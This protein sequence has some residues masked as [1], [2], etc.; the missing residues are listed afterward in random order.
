MRTDLRSADGV[1]PVHQVP[2]IGHA[3]LTDVGVKRSHNQDAF[4]VHTAGDP[5]AWQRGGHV[6]IVADGMGGHAVGEKA[7]AKAAGEIPHTYLKYADEGPATALR[8]AFLEANAGIHAVGQENPEFRGLG[9]TATALILRPEG[10][11]LGHVGDSR[12]YR[13][14]DGWVEQLTYNHSLQWELAR[15]EGVRPEDL[16]EAAILDGVKI[17]FLVAA[18]A[19]CLAI[20]A[21]SFRS[22]MPRAVA[23]PAGGK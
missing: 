14:R 8:R 20:V 7:S 12:A 18:C 2:E 6:F 1:P 13:V 9:T 4:A 16:P 23:V 19:S 17:A 11:W 5:A 15:R 22:S 3:G 10:A 21:S